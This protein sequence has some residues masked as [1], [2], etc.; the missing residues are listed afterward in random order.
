MTRRQQILIFIENYRNTHGQNSPSCADIAV[1]FRIR[2]QV[3]HR[4]LRK[5]ETEGLIFWADGKLCLTHWAQN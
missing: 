1:A 2:R 3:A 5:L 4:H